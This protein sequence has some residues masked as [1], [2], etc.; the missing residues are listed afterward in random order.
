MR[1]RNARRELPEE[2]KQKAE[3]KQLADFLD[4]QG[5]VYLRYLGSLQKRHTIGGPELSDYAK[6][7]CD[8]SEQTLSENERIAQA[9]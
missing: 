1:S 2:R 6:S 5:S 9:K 3:G 4:A 7:V 8:F